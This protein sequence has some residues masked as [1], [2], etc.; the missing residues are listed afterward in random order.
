VNPAGAP[1]R[2]QVALTAT[3]TFTPP[4]AAQ[5]WAAVRQLRRAR[6]RRVASSYAYV[7]YVIILALL[8]YAGQPISSVIG[9]ALGPAGRLPARPFPGVAVNVLTAAFAVGLLAAAR[10][11]TWRGP[12]SLSAPDVAWLLPLPVDRSPLMRGRARL[13]LCL[14]AVLGLLLGAMCAAFLYDVTRGR[15]VPLICA[16]AVAGALFGM[17]TI[18]LGTVAQRRAWISRLAIRGTPV[19][20]L[21]LLG[22]V[23]LGWW[24]PASSAAVP[25]TGPWGWSALLFARAA[26]RTT[27]AEFIAAGLL[28]AAA[29][30]GAVF[31]V[32]DAG[33]VPTARLRESA[34]V[35]AEVGAA[36]LTGETRD[37]T[38]RI[39][40]SRRGGPLR[41]R[42]PMPRQSW[43]VVPWRDCLALLRQPAGA[44]T[45]LLFV[46]VAAGV[47]VAAPSSG[48]RIALTVIS[49]LCGYVGVTRLVEPAR[50]DADDP[51]R[52]DTL[53]YSFDRL[54]LRHT[55]VPIAVLLVA[56][57]P[58]AAITAAVRGAPVLGS[59]VGVLG[60][61]PVLVGAALA[62]AYRGR[63]P[64]WL[65]FTGGDVGGLGLS[66][67]P[68]LVLW[69]AAPLLVGAGAVAY[70]VLAPH[71]GG[72]LDP[73]LFVVVVAALGA[74]VRH[75]ARALVRSTR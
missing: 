41:V 36:L 19:A 27:V 73:T 28:A 9:A 69:Y 21:L 55:A 13:M 1:D 59:L 70:V 61:I 47:G 71:R 23:A 2:E 75:R 51:R 26:Y 8:I 40:A 45:G 34:A 38:L 53:P 33:A 48:A 20:V 74:L 43:L 6:Q 22:I 57:L 10:A 3:E 32:R 62:G 58:A 15:P 18:E 25:W 16:G 14:G 31:A 4:P 50:L 5:V 54:V 42:L 46:V 64:I 72:S 52:S 65:A 30:A 67:A 17:L 24:L 63:A 29:A 66:G 35:S 56:C 7:A 44:A 49:A 39:R 68:L 37:A 12:V 11:A 60:L